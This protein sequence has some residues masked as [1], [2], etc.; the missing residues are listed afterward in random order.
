MIELVRD[1]GRVL[2]RYGSNGP[3]IGHVTRGEDQRPFAPRECGELGLERLV[4]D[5]MTGHQV[6][7]AAAHP[8]L[9]SRVGE[10]PHQI[11]MTPEPEVVVAAEVD[12]AGRPD[13]A[14][15]CEVALLEIGERG[16]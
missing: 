7:R 1:Y 12:Q 3:H 6:R 8:V 15:T 9:H 5:A 10:S 13:P 2:I 4:V 14:S 16:P 11:G